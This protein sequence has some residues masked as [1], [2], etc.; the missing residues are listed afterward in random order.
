MEK[1]MVLQV[2]RVVSVGKVAQE[3]KVERVTML[4]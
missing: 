4:Y 3:D 1:W 2:S